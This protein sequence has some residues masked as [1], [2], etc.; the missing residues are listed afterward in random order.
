[1]LRGSIKRY[2][3]DVSVIMIRSI[4]LLLLAAGSSVLTR[5][6]AAAAEPVY[7]SSSTW[8]EPVEISR[9]VGRSGFPLA[10]VDRAGTLHVIWA[11][12]NTG[13]DAYHAPRDAINYSAWNG[14]YWTQP[15]DIIAVADPAQESL[16]PIA[17]LADD[18]G[19][20]HLFWRKNGATQRGLQYS[21][22]QA[23][24]AGSAA[25]WATT[26]PVP[27][28]IF[29]ADVYHSD[30]DKIHLVFADRDGI[31]Y[32]EKDSGNAWSGTRPVYLETRVDS[33]SADSPRIVV[34]DD[35]TL[36]IAWTLTAASDDWKQAGVMYSHSFDDGG[37][38]SDPV[39]FGENARHGEPDVIIAR[40][41]S[42]LICWQ[43]SIGS[44]DGRYCAVS[45]DGGSSWPNV[46]PFNY[47]SGFTGGL[48]LVADGSRN[49][50]LLDSAGPPG[51]DGVYTELVHLEWIAGRWTEPEIVAAPAGEATS[52]TV[53]LGNQLYAL[54]H[55]H[56]G[57]VYVSQKMIDAL[58]VQPISLS[59]K[60]F[61]VSATEFATATVPNDNSNVEEAASVNVEQPVHIIAFSKT[62]AEAA[63]FSPL[64]VSTA[65][66]L[67]LAVFALVLIGL[68][69]RLVR[70]R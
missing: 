10:T 44:E 56:D 14:D 12:N 68:R 36:H 41:G 1:M 35:G 25:N 24:L 62:R 42:V 61:V 48:S 54:W 50:H 16:T 55:T 22:S 51:S 38:W 3:P 45:P 64:L 21:I 2:R 5:H 6:Q 39:I 31:Q 7:Q 19:G 67:I 20:L 69:S 37:S 49:P 18:Q 34:E 57:G 63:P 26:R 4:L 52:A 47:G 29:G 66:V 43:R 13:I 11:E 17:F 70:N 9:S 30:A 33:F 59:E 40:D 65:V 53:G 28:E 60:D 23:S 15:V 8:S 46:T 27:G 32:M 58:E